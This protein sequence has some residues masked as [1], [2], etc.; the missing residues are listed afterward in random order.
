MKLKYILPIM[1]AAGLSACSS[2]TIQYYTLSPSAKQTAETIKTSTP[3]L[4]NLLP[5]GIPPQIDMPQ[6]VIRKNDSSMTIVENARWLST[7]GDEVRSALSSNLTQRFGATDISGLAL[8]KNKPVITIQLQIRNFSVHL[9]ETVN[10][11]ADWTL[12]NV[13]SN[14]TDKLI[15]HSQISKKIS[16]TSIADI[17]IV[18]QGMM[19]DLATSM[20]QSAM[21]L[22]DNKNASCH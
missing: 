4:V 8:P 17:A 21:T 12:H 9:G 1:V 6:M 19:N 5:I 3:F 10:F 13:N 11:D 14:T 18:E 7:L 2:P 20:A 15:C 16:S 22:I